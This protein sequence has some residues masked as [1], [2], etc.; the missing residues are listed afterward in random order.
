MKISTFNKENSQNVIDLYTKVFSNSEGQKEGESIGNL[1]ADL[2]IT[3]DDRDIIGFVTVS[4]DVENIIGDT[5]IVGCVFFSRL[6]LSNKEI[7]FI[8][9]PLAVAIE[10]QRKGIGLQLIQHGID[11]LKSKKVDLLFT[12]GNPAYYSKVGFQQISED[13]VK[14]P[15]KLSQPEGWLAQSLQ[16]DTINITNTSSECV[17]AL[18]KQQYW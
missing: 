13:I 15:L 2:I 11:Y 14:A 1:V 16:R 5:M 7:A 9:S 3:T 6:T 12:Y 18:N 10:Q 8:L 17:Q 4:D